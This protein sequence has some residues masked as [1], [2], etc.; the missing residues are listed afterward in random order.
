MG[1][2]HEDVFTFMVNDEKD[3]RQTFWRKSKKN[4]RFKHFYRNHVLYVIPRNNIV[5]P[6]RLQI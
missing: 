1:T 3:Y 5:Q 2:V 4:F 6:E